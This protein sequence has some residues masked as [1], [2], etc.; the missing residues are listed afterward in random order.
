MHTNSSREQ[1]KKSHP[2]TPVH[3]F[4]LPHSTDGLNDDQIVKL[5][6]Q[7]PQLPRKNGV[8]IATPDWQQ[9]GYALSSKENTDAEK[10]LSAILKIAKLFGFSE[11]DTLTILA[12]FTDTINQLS[13]DEI[14]LLVLS[15]FSAYDLRK[16]LKNILGQ[17]SEIDIIVPQLA[18]GNKRRDIRGV[19]LTPSCVDQFCVSWQK[20]QPARMPVIATGFVLNSSRPQELRDTI[21]AAQDEDDD[22]LRVFFQTSSVRSAAVIH[23]LLIQSGCS[24]ITHTQRNGDAVGSIMD[25]TK[26]LSTVSKRA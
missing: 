21:N 4:D 22:A 8:I 7:D 24:Y 5:L 19:L 16:H 25:E 14:Q 26:Y 3:I 11:R 23:L 6:R 10:R 9:G 18:T 17:S 12:P 2:N 15:L 13:W 20:A 1:F